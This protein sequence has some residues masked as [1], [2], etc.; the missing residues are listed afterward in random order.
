MESTMPKHA[1][2]RYE[3]KDDWEWIRVIDA[4]PEQH[5]YLQF[6]ESV[7]G[8][9]SLL[10]HR[11]PV[12]EYISIMAHG[13]YAIQEQGQNLSWPGKIV[14]GGLGTATLFHVLR[15]WWPYAEITTIEC[16][17][18]VIDL[19][20]RFFRADGARIIHGDLRETLE[21]KEPGPADLIMIDCYSAVSV[22]YHLATLE[23]MFLLLE[24]LTP[25]GMVVFNLWS[26][27][28]NRI[29]AHQIRTITRAFDDC[30]MLRCRQDANIILFARKEKGP[31]PGQLKLK[32]TAYP[33]LPLPAN[34]SKAW[35]DYLQGGE[36]IDD[37]NA[38]EIFSNVGIST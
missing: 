6:E 38:A 8:V 34:E 29:C 20:K 5:R 31:W 30:A 25:K 11:M 27:D 22:P 12:L 36:V 19:A 15:D 7:Q 3:F 4:F 21:E 26:P 37:R 18:R 24:K 32:G 16:N 1:R 17:A 9:M 13:T 35:P 33:F 14:L 2:L 10:E 23:F 28:C